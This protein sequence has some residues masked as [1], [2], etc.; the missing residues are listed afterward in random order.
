ML[1]LVLQCPSLPLV[2]VVVL[3]GGDIPVLMV[4]CTFIGPL[5]ILV[6]VVN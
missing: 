4:G 6:Y 2:V 5:L 3:L 1:L